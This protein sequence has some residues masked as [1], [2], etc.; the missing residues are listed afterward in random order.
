VSAELPNEVEERRVIRLL[1]DV[2]AEVSPL[3]SEDVDHLLAAAMRRRSRAHRRSPGLHH[4]LATGAA[5]AVVLGVALG[6]TASHSQAPSREPASTSASLA[7]FPE[8]SALQLLLS[9]DATER[10]S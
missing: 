5:A 7:S 6:L 2:A 4:L 3:P 1:A 8:G 9:T 10:R